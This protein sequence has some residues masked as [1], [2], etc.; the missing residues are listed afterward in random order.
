MAVYFVSDFHL[1]AADRESERLKLDL[2]DRFV[3]EQS[4]DLDHLVII[5]DLFDFWFEYRHLI[6]KKHIRILTTLYGLR[7]SGCRITYICGN[8]DFWLGD[9]MTAQLGIEVARDSYVLETERGSILITH[10]DGI[11]SGD[12]GYRIMK[13]IFRN[14]VSVALYKLLPPAVAIHSL[15][16]SRAHR[17]TG[18]MSLPVRSVSRSTINMH[19]PN[20]GTGILLLSVVI[21]TPQKSATSGRTST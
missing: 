10:G 5:G 7:T 11:S 8:H 6:P 19:S 2:F 9:F 20:S 13:Q 17:E 1:G 18:A 16:Q 14:R 4:S 12:R 15:R 21:C 3:T